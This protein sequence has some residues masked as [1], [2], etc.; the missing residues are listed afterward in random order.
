[1]A[2]APL[3]VSTDIRQLTPIQRAVLLNPEVIAIDQQPTAGD[4]ISPAN[5]D[6]VDTPSAHPSSKILPRSLTPM[7]SSVSGAGVQSPPAPGTWFV[8]KNADALPDRPHEECG[9][10]HNASFTPDGASCQQLCSA[11]ASCTIYEWSAKSSTCWFRLDGDWTQLRSVDLRESGCL[12]G[13][14][15]TCGVGPVPPPPPPPPPPNR[16]DCQ[17]WA[18]PLVETTYP[19]TRGESL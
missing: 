19:G 6:P 9:R 14:V 8:V 17:I 12:V 15:A 3:L 11:N 2:S 16:G 18:K 1:M 10:F 13:K 4:L 5:C 7:L